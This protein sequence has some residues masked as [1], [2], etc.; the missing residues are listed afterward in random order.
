[1]NGGIEDRKIEADSNDYAYEVPKS[2]ELYK[3][4]GS[5]GAV[6]IEGWGTGDGQAPRDK[7]GADEL[8]LRAAPLAEEPADADK[9]PYNF[10][11]IATYSD[12]MRVALQWINEASGGDAEVAVFHNDSPFGTAP[13]GDGKDYIEDQGFDL[14][15]EPYA[16]PATS[17]FV[18][19]LSQAKKQGAEYVVIQNVASPAAQVAKDIQAQNLDMKIV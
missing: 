12:Q 6:A 18:G 7:G 9:S 16:M 8:P 19:L 1:E 11:N 2:E 13:V 3:K 15:Y 14:G 5:D 17:N 10:V 4:Y